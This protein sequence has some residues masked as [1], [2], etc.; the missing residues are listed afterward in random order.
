MPSLTGF[1]LGTSLRPQPLAQS[2]DLLYRVAMVLVS[3]LREEVKAPF[4]TLV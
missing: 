3:A 2:L 4:I 1:K